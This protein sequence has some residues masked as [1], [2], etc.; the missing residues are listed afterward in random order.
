MAP[1]AMEQ[2]LCARER[3]LE[4]LACI[5]A[6]M[7][8][9]DDVDAMIADV[10]EALLE[11]FGADRAWLLF[12]CDPEAPSWRVPMEKTRPAYP[13]AFAE[14]R[15]VPMDEGVAAQ[16][17]EALQAVG[18]VAYGYADDAPY[19]EV[20]RE[21]QIQSG[22]FVALFPR[23]G[24][25]W[26]LGMHQCAYLRAWSREERD[27]FEDIADRMGDVLTNLLLVR[28]LKADIEQRRRVERELQ[29]HR[30]HLQEL[31]EAQT[32]DL[33]VAK[34]KAEQAN[35]AKSL[36]LANMSH[37]LRTPMHAVLS[38]A[39]LGI[40]KA[41]TAPPERLKHYFGRIRDSGGRLM[42]LLNDL[43]DLAK[44]ESGRMVYRMQACTLTELAEDLVAEFEALIRDHGL[45][46]EILP[47]QCP[48]RVWADRAKLLQVGR[49]LL[50][51]AIRFSPRGGRIAIA[52]EAA[53]L[54]QGRRE[55]DR[56][57]R[58]AVAFRIEDQG[59]GIP[60][61]ELEAV[62]DMF[63]QASENRSGAGGTGLGLAISREIVE[64]HRG[65]IWARNRP[66]GGAEFTFVI[67]CGPPGEGQ[68]V[69]DRPATPLSE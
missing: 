68:G 9:H 11:L 58:A 6:V 42:V 18:S 54:P 21:F 38:F 69:K 28:E 26:L 24:A 57:T 13:G 3:H 62:F 16:L 59:R 17:R 60:Q 36:F 46:C 4:S 67:P 19:A 53:S 10:L 40:D 29:R 15:E 49:N 47:P 55:G 27:L 7:A 50:S 66:Q 8:R 51:N 64:A 63:V 33:K 48:T 52:F 14:A 61:G 20:W 45:R 2:A 37:E 5:G 31:V 35:R 39:E 34:E 56:G 65:R 30:D 43:L 1:E 12:P 41:A 44:L 25:P 32:A 22:L 23:L